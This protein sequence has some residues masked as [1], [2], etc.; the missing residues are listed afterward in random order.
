MRFFKALKAHNQSAFCKY[1]KPSGKLGGFFALKP[2]NLDACL[3]AIAR[4][5]NRKEFNI[6]AFWLR[7]AAR[8][9]ALWERTCSAFRKFSLPLWSLSLSGKVSSYL[10]ASNRCLKI[11]SQSKPDIPNKA[12]QRPW[13]RK[14]KSAPNAAFTMPRAMRI[15]ATFNPDQFALKAETLVLPQNL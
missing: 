2:I 3:F 10:T 1:L 8:F 9:F 13:P 11:S 15:A 6:R 5:L 12:S 14:W 7:D 4:F